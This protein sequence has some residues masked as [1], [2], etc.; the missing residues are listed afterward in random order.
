MNSFE[1]LMPKKCYLSR[2]VV[3]LHGCNLR[4][5]AIGVNVVGLRRRLVLEDDAAVIIAWY[6]RVAVLRLI[7]LTCRA[8]LWLRL[9]N[10]LVFF[11][12][13]GNP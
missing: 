12:Q 7:G 13:A 1:E 6:I 4:L 5:N 10:L 3:D 8:R 2:D 9:A 11:L